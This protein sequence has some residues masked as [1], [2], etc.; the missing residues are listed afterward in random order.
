MTVDECITR[1]EKLSKVI[2]GRKHM[3]SRITLGLAPAR[4]SGKRLRNC[5]RTL[6]RDRGLGEDMSMRHEADG[7]AW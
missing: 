5:V 3:R 2:F 7:V 1:Y 6:L 4:Y